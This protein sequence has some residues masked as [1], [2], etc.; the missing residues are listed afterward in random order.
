MTFPDKRLTEI[1]E[2]TCKDFSMQK[3]I[4]TIEHGW[5]DNKSEVPL[6][7]AAYFNIRESLSVIDGLVVRGDA[8]VIP[9][10]LRADIK[11]RLHSSHLGYDSMVRR[12]R[13]TVYWPNINSDIRQMAAQCVTCQELKPKPTKTPLI[14]H[15]DGHLPW[16]KIGLDLFEIKGRNY[17]ISVD[18]YSNFIEVDYL[19]TTTSAQVIR[20]L[21]KTIRSFWCTY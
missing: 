2:E 11:K 18:Y 10:A 9:K 19:S 17:L 13:S 20:M 3:L 6:A 15:D 14:Q 8:V 21:K 5:P 16:N 4:N 12:A 7:C 1:R